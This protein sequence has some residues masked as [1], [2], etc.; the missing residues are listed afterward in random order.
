[1]ADIVNIPTAKLRFSTSLADFNN[2]KQ[3]EK[4]DKTGNTYITEAKRNAVKIPTTNLVFTTA[5]RSRKALESDPN[6][7]LDNRK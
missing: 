4:D 6:S 7:E 3:P 5:E 2:D 1:M